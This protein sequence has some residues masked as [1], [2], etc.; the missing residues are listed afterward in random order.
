MP[1]YTTT[2]FN[3]DGSVHRRRNLEARDDDHALDLTG[4]SDHPYAMAL[5]LGERCVGYFRS[6]F[7]PLAWAMKATSPY[8]P[9]PAS[10]ARSAAR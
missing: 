10:Q 9:P 7:L 4:Q 5:H 3:K 8:P 1:T 6:Q 2:Y